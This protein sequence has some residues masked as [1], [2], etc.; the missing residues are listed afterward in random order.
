[1]FLFL[2]DTAAF[3]ALL[4]GLFRVFFVKV[5]YYTG[6]LTTNWFGGA[7]PVGPGMQP[8]WRP[9]ESIGESHSTK[10]R[11]IDDKMTVET[12][13]EQPLELDFSIE[14]WPLVNQLPTFLR[15]TKEQIENAIK[16]RVKSLLSIEAR[17]ATNYDAVFD[18]IKPIADSVAKE[19]MSLYSAQYGIGLRF[20]IDDPE[21]PAELAK[22]A[23][24]LGVATKEVE[25]KLIEI[26]GTNKVR[27]K[28][29]TKLTTLANGVVRK[30]K[31]NG[32][33]MDFQTALREVRI[34]LKITEETNQN[35]GLTKETLN[36]VGGGIEKGIEVAVGKVLPGLIKKH[37]KKGS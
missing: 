36:T 30:T 31:K 11:V 25:R 9:V 15:F 24:E 33:D 3:V 28:E 8:L 34:G 27:G 4:A 10:E 17:K 26:D 22:K 16:Q 2:L 7:R 20:M 29:M 23:V 19:F 35:F 37:F 14:Y 13:D 6:S 18:Q 1:M 21:L 12:A 5:P 32:G